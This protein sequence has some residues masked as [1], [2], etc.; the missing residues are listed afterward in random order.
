MW[1]LR[2]TRPG[3]AILTFQ[4]VDGLQYVVKAITQFF[5]A[6]FSPMQKRVEKGCFFSLPK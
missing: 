4:N 5:W 2:Q 6:L 3:R 1:S